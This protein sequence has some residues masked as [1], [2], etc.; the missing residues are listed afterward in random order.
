MPNLNMSRFETLV[1]A[2]LQQQFLP[3]DQQDIDAIIF[4]LNGEKQRMLEDVHSYTDEKTVEYYVRTRQHQLVRLMDL[5]METNDDISKHI[6]K[7]LGELLNFLE[8]DFPRYLDEDCQLPGIYM[9]M[10]REILI[11]EI[12]LISF[13]MGNLDEQLKSIVMK[14]YRIF[15]LDGVQISYH[16]MFY[17]QKLLHE[18]Y[19]V[20]TETVSIEDVQ[21]VLLQFDFNDPEYFSYFIEILRQNI[22]EA[23]SIKDKKEK[24]FLF[25]KYFNQITVHPGMYLKK[26]HKPLKE[27]LESWLS[28]ELGF[29]ENYEGLLSDGYLPAEQ[30]IWKDFKVHTT[31][32][33]PQLG[34]L[35]G[36]LLMSGII[37]NKNKKELASF[38]SVFFTSPKSD[39]VTMDHV[40]N[41][42][43]DKSIGLANS[44][45]DI[46][47]K[48]INLSRE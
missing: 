11:D 17:L 44:I 14:P 40:R 43:Y 10:G 21:L 12:E 48:L 30:E 24:I 6:F 28:A 37:L 19:E 36:L 20:L 29:L 2:A 31:L 35:V 13:R 42:F 38:F 32:S 16:E 9:E 15:L 8:K 27:Q 18:L 26:L 34:R 45:R 46:L 7:S 25:Q 3:I 47:A 1:H 39:I 41:S 22:D 23:V 33:V 5:V 4:E